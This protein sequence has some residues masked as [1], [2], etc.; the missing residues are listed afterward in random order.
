LNG[1]TFGNN[2]T[3]IGRYAFESC[4]ALSSANFKNP[5]GWRYISIYGPSAGTAV[6]ESDM[7]DFTRA[8]EHLLNFNHRNIYWKRG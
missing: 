7:A 8:A 4:A 2:V 6:D 1:I 3:Y 5:T